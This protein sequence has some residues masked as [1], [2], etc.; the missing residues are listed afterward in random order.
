MNFKK[1][2]L[3]AGVLVAA[4]L[5]LT[6][7]SEPRRQ[8]ELEK[9]KLFAAVDDG[10]VSRLSES[11]KEGT[12]YSIMSVGAGEGSAAWA[13]TDLPTAKLDDGA[14]RGLIG[15]LKGLTFEGPLSDAEVGSDLTIFGLAS[16]TLTI[17]LQLKDSSQ[18][19][20]AFG[21]RSDYLNKRYAKVSGAPGLYLVDEAS[22]QS[23]NKGRTDIRDKTPIS[24][25]TA[26]VREVVLDSSLGRILITQPAVGE[27]KEWTQR[28]APGPSKT[29]RRS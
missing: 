11:P 15:T 16:P 8:A 27:W 21:K 3:L 26:D 10:Q 7:V 5:Y 19:E 24:F 17:T 9:D 12:P 20:V 18:K 4:V 6:K 14:V 22:F 25:N 1:T 13:F 23:L 2:V 28:L 29:L